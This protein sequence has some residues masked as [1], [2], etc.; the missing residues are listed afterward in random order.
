M[1]RLR[2]LLAST[3]IFSLL[4]LISAGATVADEGGVPNGAADPTAAGGANSAADPGDPNENA[5][6]VGESNGGAANADANSTVVLVPIVEFDHATV[7]DGWVRYWYE[8]VNIADFPPELFTAAPQLP[9]CGLNTN[10]SRT[11]ITFFDADTG[12]RIYGY[13]AIIGPPDPLV[14]WFVVPDGTPPPAA[15]EV[16]FWDR[17]TDQRYRSASVGVPVVE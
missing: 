8:I 1:F 9:P 17:E 11:W 16:E 4:M 5:S 13:C 10:A 3:A 2:L 7:E 6:E 12:A 14:L 15:I